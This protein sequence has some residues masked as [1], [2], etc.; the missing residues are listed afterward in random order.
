MLLLSPGCDVYFAGLRGDTRA[1][2]NNGW[3]FAIEREVERW[4]YYRVIMKHPPSGMFMDGEVDIESMQRA[5]TRHMQHDTRD[6]KPVINVRHAGNSGQTRIHAF[7]K[8]PD[9]DRI[10]M[11]PQLKAVSYQEFDYTINE[12]SVFKPW[13]P[14]AQELIVD[15]NSVADLMNRIKSLQ[16]PEL[17][18]IRKRNRVRDQ[19]DR[20]NEQILAQVI[21]IS[22]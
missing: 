21:A 15:P 1:M 2:Q 20:P 5:A 11:S 10:D 13:A 7:N 16:D 12:L 9:F 19:R 6:C 4:R 8:M 3:E 22:N 14:N 18:A 17:A